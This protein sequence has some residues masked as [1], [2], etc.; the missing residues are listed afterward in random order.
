MLNLPPRRLNLWSFVCWMQKNAR[1]VFIKTGAK[2]KHESERMPSGLDP[3]PEQAKT[4][5]TF[6]LVQIQTSKM[7]QFPP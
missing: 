5:F 7:Q 6:I 1:T 3:T 4:F 2:L